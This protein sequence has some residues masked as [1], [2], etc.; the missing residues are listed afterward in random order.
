MY[1]LICIFILD[2]AEALIQYALVGLTPVCLFQ[3]VINFA[4]QSAYGC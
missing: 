1:F 4:L 3:R 2:A